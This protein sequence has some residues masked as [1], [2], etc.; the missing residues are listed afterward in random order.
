V[1]EKQSQD[2]EFPLGG[3][4]KFPSYKKTGPMNTHDAQNVRPD[5]LLEGRTRGGK[6][7][8]LG[9]AY[10]S[11]IGSGNPVNMLAQVRSLGD[12]Q[13]ERFTD[14]F[15]NWTIPQVAPEDWEEAGAWLNTFTGTTNYDEPKLSDT[16]EAQPIP[17]YQKI[18]ATSLTGADTSAT[19][20]SPDISDADISTFEDGF[21]GT[22]GAVVGLRINWTG[23]TLNDPDSS[24]ELTITNITS[25]NGEWNLYPYDDYA[26]G[27][28]DASEVV[29]V[30]A[31]GGAFVSWP[32]LPQSFIDAMDDS[33]GS[34]AI[35]AVPNAH[36]GWTLTTIGL[37]A[38]YSPFS[39]VSAG[40]VILFT[41]GANANT[42]RVIGSA[43]AQAIT[44]D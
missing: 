3:M 35:R 21:T 17:S 41:S 38:T 11:Q 1:A 5:A 16:Y 36:E 20:A 2:L 26:A 15:T 7:P 4:N 43:T 8:G 13:F 29:T 23:P 12:R 44:V 39:G 28:V 32:S 27:T 22:S 42:A 10:P 19:A 14:D 24:I 40:D 9:N 6:R 33:T 30:A 34:Y 31:F 25:I 37:A 18:T